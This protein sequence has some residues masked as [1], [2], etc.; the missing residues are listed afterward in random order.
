MGSA[1]APAACC[2]TPSDGA[3]ESGSAS[4]LGGQGADSASPAS[5]GT[6]SSN[7]HGSASPAAGDALSASPASSACGTPRTTPNSHAFQ[8]VYAFSGGNTSD[9][10]TNPDVA[11]RSLV[12]Y[13]AQL[14][15]AQGQYR[16][17]LVD[18]AMQP[19]VAAGKKVILRVSA[20]GWAKWDTAANSAHGTPAWVYAQGVKSVTEQDGAVLPEYWNPA[21]EKDMAAFLQAFAARYDGNANVAAVDISIGVGGESKA[22]SEKNDNLLSLWQ[23]IGYT[24]ELWWQYAQE[25]ITAYTGVFHRTPLALMPD[26]TFIGG[27]DGY[28]EEKIVDYA[29]AKG[30]WLQDNG[31]VPGRTLSAPWGQT[32]VIAE[33]RGATSETGDNLA[34]DLKAA[35]AEHPVFVLVFTSD[36]TDANR[37]VLHQAAARATAAQAGPHTPT[38]SASGS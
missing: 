6:V 17:D 26:K 37:D 4:P 22:D 18:Q 34:D 33:M 5:P 11:G 30:I 3:S 8:G 38:G 13:W 15:P 27:T 20:S 12:F 35:L 21:F 23:S 36:I 31:V 1:A 19:W 10:A 29:V 16:W 14:E 2:G 28:N 24:D 25:T 9:L 7:V 32:P